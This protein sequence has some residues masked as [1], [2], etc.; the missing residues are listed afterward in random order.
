MLAGSKGNRVK[1]M[2]LRDEFSLGIV[3]PIVQSHDSKWYRFPHANPDHVHEYF[4]LD[5]DVAD[6][7]GV[8]K[9]N[10]PVP[11]CMAGEV[12]NL[13]GYTLSFDIENWKKYPTLIKDDEEVIF[14]EKVHGTWYND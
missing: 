10:P 1:P 5:Q 13:N 11:T 8:T 14:T 2:R 4:E 6:F 3:L 12:C 9:Y 7:L